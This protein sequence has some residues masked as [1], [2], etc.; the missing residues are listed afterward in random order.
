MKGWTTTFKT[1]LTAAIERSRRLIGFLML[2]PRALMGMTG[3]LLVCVG[4]ILLGAAGLSS[5]AQ[6]V[7]LV[8]SEIPLVEGLKGCPGEK[9]PPANE[10]ADAVELLTAAQVHSLK[11]T[12]ALKNCEEKNE[13]LYGLIERH[14]QQVREMNDRNWWERLFG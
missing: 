6:S 13:I 2:L 14:N 10:L 8:G 9:L 11:Q 7:R 3:F 5:C 4:L 12:M 1:L